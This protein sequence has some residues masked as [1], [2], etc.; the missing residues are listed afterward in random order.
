MKENFLEELHVAVN[1]GDS[2]SEAVKKIIAIDKLADKKLG[3]TTKFNKMNDD[4]L[5]LIVKS[6]INKTKTMK[7]KKRSLK[8]RIKSWFFEKFLQ[9]YLVSIDK[10]FIELFIKYDAK[11]PKIHIESRA[12]KEYKR[13]M[14]TLTSEG[15]KDYFYKIVKYDRHTAESLIKPYGKSFKDK[16]FAF[17]AENYIRYFKKDLY[18]NI[19]QFQ[20]I[21]DG[22][23]ILTNKVDEYMANTTIE[24]RL[25]R[26]TEF[27]IITNDHKTAHRRLYN[28]QAIGAAKIR[29]R[30][31]L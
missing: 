27:G 21:R 29:K 5:I 2:D 13:I 19:L 16:V 10:M 15:F 23:I 17:I 20:R 3:K 30:N 18:E 31:Q 25:D 7:K 4:D 9:R 14:K 11:V 24:E 12:E 26:A 6:D 8:V 22:I 28:M 1:T